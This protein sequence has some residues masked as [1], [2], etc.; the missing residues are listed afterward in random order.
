MI[1]T[2]LICALILV[3][4]FAIAYKDKLDIAREE[5]E[6]FAQ[7]VLQQYE[8]IDEIVEALT[9]EQNEQE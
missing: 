8:W 1:V 5:R 3:A 7:E 2:L 4:G 6:F 9:E